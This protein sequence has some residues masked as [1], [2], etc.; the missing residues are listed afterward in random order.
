MKKKCFKCNIIKDLSEFHRHLDMSDGHLNKC[1]KCTCKYVKEQRQKKSEYYKEYDRKRGSKRGVRIYKDKYTQNNKSYNTG[2][3]GAE[4]RKLHLWVEKELGKPD[5]C[6]H[7]RKNGLFGHRVHWANVSG[8]YK[9]QK[10][11]WI[12]LCA[13]CHKKYDLLE[14]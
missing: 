2:K 7:C 12:R 4:Y 10:N 14:I 3:F 5:E 1:K 6:V 8:E 13:A 11:D 9:K